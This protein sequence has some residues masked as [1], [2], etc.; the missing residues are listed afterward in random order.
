MS[1]VEMPD[2][3]VENPR[4]RR[5]GILVLPNFPM[6]AYSSLVEPLRAANTVTGLPLYEWITVSPFGRIPKSSSGLGVVVDSVAEEAPSVDRLVVVSGVDAHEY[7]SQPAYSWI[8]RELRRGAAIGAVSD[9]A[10]F[11]ARAGL[12]D[13]YRC[14]LH[15]RVQS[16][17][18]E[19]FPKIECS[20]DPFVIDRDR[21]SAAGG[22]S[23]LD[24]MLAMIEADYGPDLTLAVS[25]WFLHNRFRTSDDMDVLSIRLR[26]GVGDG[27]IL[28]AIVEMEQNIEEPLP[29]DE[30]ARRIGVSVDTLERGFKRA[31]GQTTMHYYRSLRFRRARDLLEGTALRISEIAVACGFSDSSSFARAYRTHFGVSPRQYRQRTMDRFKSA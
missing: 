24:M 1:T 17:F 26:T 4:T 2:V 25:E 7:T 18:R 30:L 8:R 20:R 15:W 29:A 10:F 31:V 21:F 6:L 12:L 3:H 27:R 5:W 13:G 16:S 14:T 11:L 22:V 23:T 19:A 9:G 28:Q